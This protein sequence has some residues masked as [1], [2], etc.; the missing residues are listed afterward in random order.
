MAGWKHHA[1]KEKE[2]DR[3][4]CP[5]LKAFFVS[6]HTYASKLVSTTGTLTPFLCCLSGKA[7]A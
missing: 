3:G 1:A 7:P 2:N 5:A 4:Y 6:V